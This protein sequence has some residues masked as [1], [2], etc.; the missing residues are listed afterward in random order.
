MLRF[1]ILIAAISFSA[2][3]VTKSTQ[4]MH[5]FD[6]G[7]VGCGN[8]IVYKL[9]GDNQ[10]Y[11]SVVLDVTSI[12]LQKM[13]AYSVD[14]AEVVKVKRKKYDGPINASLCND[15]MM[16]K[17][18]ELLEEVAIDGIVEV[19]VDLLEKE[20]AEKKEPYK[21]TIVL[22]KIVFETMTIDYLRLENINVGWLP[23]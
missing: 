17:P 18:N 23:G 15:V 12:E 13:Q 8:F 5:P 16:Q 10:E 21:V 20:K 14:K 3:S 6:G 1:I 19:Y 9:S 22:K 11:V 4:S 2:C 7:S